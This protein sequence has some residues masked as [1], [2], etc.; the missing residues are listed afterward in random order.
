MPTAH[1][2][3]I[4]KSQLNIRMAPCPKNIT[5]TSKY[6]VDVQNKERNTLAV[7]DGHQSCYTPVCIARQKL[8]DAAAICTKQPIASAALSANFHRGKN[9]C[10]SKA[11]AGERVAFTKTTQ[12]VGVG[13]QLNGFA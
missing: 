11:A 4:S 10:S 6:G 1:E 12:L 2:V 7:S 13:L 9:F 8:S 3:S 5:R